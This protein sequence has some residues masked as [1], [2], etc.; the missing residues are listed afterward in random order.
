ML[1]N[2]NQIRSRTI[3][4]SALVLIGQERV[5][6]LSLEQLDCVQKGWGSDII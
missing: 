3:S 2:I 5:V 6:T 1:R 4:L